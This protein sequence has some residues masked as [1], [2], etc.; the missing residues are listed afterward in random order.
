MVWNFAKI[1]KRLSLL[2]G[3]KQKLKN[4]LGYSKDQRFHVIVRCCPD[5]DCHK[6]PPSVA[7]CWWMEP[8]VS[9][10]QTTPAAQK[11]LKL[12]RE[13]LDMQPFGKIV[14]KF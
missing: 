7:E 11:Q 12:E 2:M 9:I 13:D 6:A 1:L 8:G 10:T 14:L 4:V 5:T 3:V